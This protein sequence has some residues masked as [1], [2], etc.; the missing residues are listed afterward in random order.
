VTTPTGPGWWPILR[1]RYVGRLLTWTTVGRLPHGMVPIALVL[2]VREAGGSYAWGTMLAALYGLALAAGQ[3][4]L[5]RIVDRTGQ[6]RPTLIAAV[7]SAAATAALVLPATTA[8]ERPVMAVATVVAAGA[9]APPLEATLRAL[10]PLLVPTHAKDAAYSLDSTSQEAAHVLAPGLVALGAITTGPAGV[11]AAAAALGAL[12][13]LGVATAPPSR[14]W[15]PAPRIDAAAPG[16]LGALHAPAMWLVLAALIA[17]G[18]VIGTVY[19]AGP[20]LAERWDAPWLSGTLP[21]ALSCSAMLGNALWTLARWTGLLYPRL[22]TLTAA[23]AASWLGL[24]AAATPTHAVAAVAVSGL[25]F[26]PVLTTGYHLIDRLAPPGTTVE[27]FSLL[28]SAVYIGVALGT[29]I[30][31]NHTDT[32][33]I[34]PLTAALL[35]LL[36]AL[37]MRL[38]LKPAP[39][40]SPDQPEPASP[41]DGPPEARPH[42]MHAMQSR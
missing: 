20:V 2:L 10:W 30:A 24:L 21:A 3:P 12:G 40:P 1:T 41:R 9:G 31:G 37:S 32:P 15:R 35:L 42:R 7:L 33:A 29:S 11:L 19:T 22:V 6:T 23:Y 39:A 5:G 25:F 13:A 4:V 18:S 16:R 36:L 34:P 27:A 8:P 17:F 14:A 28:V 26:G 38:V